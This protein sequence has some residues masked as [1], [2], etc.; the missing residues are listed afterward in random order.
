MN[1]STRNFNS[2]HAACLGAPYIRVSVKD[3]PS[4]AAVEIYNTSVIA[5][6][7]TEKSL[8]LYLQPR[9]F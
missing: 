3:P 8:F 2:L 7:S 6:F 9:K 5:E 4:W 1:C